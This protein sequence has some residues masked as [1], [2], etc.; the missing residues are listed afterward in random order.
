MTPQFMGSE[1]V[2][3]EQG[4]YAGTRVFE[5]EDAGGIVSDDNAAVRRRPAMFE[6]G[7]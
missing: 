1:P 6:T 2:H 4:K 3:A 5:V 7:H